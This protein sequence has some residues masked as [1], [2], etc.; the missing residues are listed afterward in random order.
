[1]E[2]FRGSGYIYG[3]DGSDGFMDVYLSQNSSSCIR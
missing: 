3:I 1:M 2:T